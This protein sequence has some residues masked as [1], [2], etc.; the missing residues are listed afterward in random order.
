LIS[1]HVYGQNVPKALREDNRVIRS[2]TKQVDKNGWLYFKKN[3]RLTERDLFTDLKDAFGL[4][5]NDKMV[6]LK[7][8]TAADG[9]ERHQRFRQHYQNIPI[10][11]AE[12]F[13]HYNANGELNTG[14]GKIVEGLTLS[15]RARLTEAQALVHAT[16]DIGARLYAWQDTSWEN[17][18]KREK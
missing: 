5:V 9:S 13:L 10:E 7:D 4:T 3:L 11:D 15:N 6:M 12:Y 16:R 17:S 1:S 14:S 18:I 8:E 2:L